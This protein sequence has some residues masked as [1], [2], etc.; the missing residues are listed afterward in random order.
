MYYAT[1]CAGGVGYTLMRYY[2]DCPLGM[3]FDMAHSRE[4]FRNVTRVFAL[5]QLPPLRESSIMATIM[6]R[7]CSRRKNFSRFSQVQRGFPA[8]MSR[9]VPKSAI[10]LG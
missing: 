8:K 5:Q 6:A 4:F 9:F 10:S 3:D 2:S 7:R 1:H